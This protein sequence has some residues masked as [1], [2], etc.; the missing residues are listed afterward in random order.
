[1]LKGNHIRAKGDRRSHCRQKRIVAVCFEAAFRHAIGFTWIACDEFKSRRVIKRQPA[2]EAVFPLPANGAG[3]QNTFIQNIIYPS[4]RW[5]TRLLCFHQ[6]DICGWNGIET[7]YILACIQHAFKQQGRLIFMLMARDD[8]R[9][10]NI[11][12]DSWR[13]PMVLNGRLSPFHL[14]VDFTTE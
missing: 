10:D 5:P 12:C 8:N 11:F 2:A 3:P 9:A 7:D 1:M 14:P 6:R 4:A 13:K